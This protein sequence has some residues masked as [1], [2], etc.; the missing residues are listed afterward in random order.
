MAFVP[1]YTVEQLQSTPNILRFIDDSTGSDPNIASVRIY[2]EKSDGTYLVPEGTTTDYIIWEFVERSKNV[3]VLDKDYALNVTV[4]WLNLAN[5]ALYTLSVLKCFSKYS[6]NFSYNL[7]TVQASSPS[8]LNDEDYVNSRMIL[9]SEIQSAK[10]CVN[11]FSD[12]NN[13][14]LCLDRAKFLMDGKT[15]NF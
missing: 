2:L 10:K 11:L 9:S 13:S 5:V 14:Q 8:F 4:K 6:E 12:I 3:N 1:L 7:T 15:S